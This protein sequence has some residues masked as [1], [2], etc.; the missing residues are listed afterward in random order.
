[1]TTQLQALLMLQELDA[2]LRDLGDASWREKEEA[3]GFAVGSPNKLRSERAR[4]AQGLSPELLRRYEQVR[5]RYPRAV[6]PL[7]RGT[8]LGCFMVRPTVTA[9]H[10]DRLE[11][12]ERCGRILFRLEERRQPEPPPSGDGARRGRRGGVRARP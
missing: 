12:C 9:T 11:T 4:I 10:A 7:R 6:A 5:Q 8:C 2:L 1:M 3:L